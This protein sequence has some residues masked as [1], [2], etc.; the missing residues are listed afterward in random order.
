M[1]RILNIE[2]ATSVCS[3]SISENGA[4]IAM[5][6]SSS[7]YSHAELLSSFVQ[8]IIHEAGLKLKDL[9]AIAV[10]MGPGSYTGLRIGVSSAKG[11]C[12][13]LEKPLIA[14]STLQSMALGMTELIAGSEHAKNDKALFCPMIDARRMEVYASLFDVRNQEVRKIQADIIDADSYLEYLDAGVVYFAGD[15]AEKC[16]EILGVSKNAKYIDEFVI[17]S[18]DMIQIST[19]KFAAKD[20][21]DLAYFEPFYLKDFIAG[22]PSV[23]GLR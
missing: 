7:A 1:S 8:D 11:L 16:M 13:A 15:G 12:Y 5:K 22:K 18:K 9:D 17:S 3:V 2:T 20:F 14:V 4:L 19:A 21:A 23:K 10:S 6:E